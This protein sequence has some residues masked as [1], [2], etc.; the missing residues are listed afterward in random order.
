ME[1]R[2]KADERV[3]DLDTPESEAEEV[4]GGVNFG[5]LKIGDIKGE[6]TDAKHPD[7]LR[8]I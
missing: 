8:G 7:S 5:A 3:E 2:E 6:S 4:K 1:D